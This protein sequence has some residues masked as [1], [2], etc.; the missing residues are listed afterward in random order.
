MQ[1]FRLMLHSLTNLSM[2]HLEVH[3]LEMLP[4]ALV[5]WGSLHINLTNY[6]LAA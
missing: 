3:H 6:C 1:D 4:D 2:L 5:R